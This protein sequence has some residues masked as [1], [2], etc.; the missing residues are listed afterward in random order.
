MHIDDYCFG[1]IDI[2]GRHYDSD[3]IV[4]PET[5][6]DGWW[7][8]HG[9]RLGTDD[10]DPALAADPEVLVVGTGFHGRMAVPAATR[11]ALAARGITLVCARTGEA[12]Q[13]FNRLQHGGAR[14]VAALHLTC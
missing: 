13:R 7:R 2:Q 9:H 14:V 1:D 10:L 11:E 5:V 6:I 3:V 12:V 4:T 8:Q